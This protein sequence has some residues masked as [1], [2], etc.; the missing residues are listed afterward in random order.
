MRFGA[1]STISARSRATSP[2]FAHTCLSIS[3]E[4]PMNT[5]RKF[6]GDLHVTFATVVA[7]VGVFIATVF[8]ISAVYA[9]H[10]DPVG[11]TVQFVAGNPDC[12]D[13]STDPNVIEL[14]IQPVADGTYSDG[15]LTVTIDVRDTAGGP[16]FDWTSNIPIG[17][18]FVKGGPNGNLYTYTPPFTSDTNL[19]APVNP[20]NGSYY[21]LSHI[22]FCY[23]PDATITIDP[24]T[25]VNEV[26]DPHPLPP[27]PT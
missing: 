11:R 12:G 3:E 18:V 1:H 19:H 6:P 7:M 13:L 4:E 23:S 20:S 21:G 22:S 17:T 8:A 2:A 5:V 24:P 15:T 14:K 26:G 27:P 25:G 10:P 9:D 16:V